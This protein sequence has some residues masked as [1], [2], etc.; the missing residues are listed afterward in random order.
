MIYLNSGE[1]SGIFGLFLHSA[2]LKILIG[3]CNCLNIT[4][5]P[6][7]AS[8]G[9]NIS[10]NIS[11]V[12]ALDSW[13]Q[14]VHISLNYALRCMHCTVLHWASWAELASSKRSMYIASCTELRR[15]P[16]HTIYT[17]THSVLLF[18]F[19]WN[20]STSIVFVSFAP[21]FFL[22]EGITVGL[23]PWQWFYPV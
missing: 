7:F 23:L 22:R 6:V 2:V 17:H 11:S 13:R 15:S 4:S 18:A 21:F 9:G 12:V 10:Q 1:F 19:A 5:L 20:T 16:T 8:F 14:H 3:I